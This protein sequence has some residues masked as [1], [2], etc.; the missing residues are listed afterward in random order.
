ADNF[1]LTTKNWILPQQQHDFLQKLKKAYFDISPSIKAIINHQ[2]RDHLE[3]KKDHL[4]LKKMILE[5]ELQRQPRIQ[6][7]APTTGSSHAP[8]SSPILDKLKKE[9]SMPLGATGKK[10]DQSL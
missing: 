4:E 7:E 9:D 5:S 3:L 1:F 6:D 2:H 10:P 8:A